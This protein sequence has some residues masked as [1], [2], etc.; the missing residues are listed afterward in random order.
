MLKAYVEKEEPRK[1]GLRD[2]KRTRREG[3]Q[4]ESKLSATALTS[5][6]DDSKYALGFGREV[7]LN[8]RESFQ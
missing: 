6:T 8:L 7:I 2:G 5:S 1:D 4:K 3:K